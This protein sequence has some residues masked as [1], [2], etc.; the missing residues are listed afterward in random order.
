M[1]TTLKFP[2][3]TP[4]VTVCPTDGSVYTFGRLPV[5]VNDVCDVFP[6]TVDLPDGKSYQAVIKVCKDSANLRFLDR[7][8]D[9]LNQFYALA[10]GDPKFKFF[11]HTLTRPL[12]SILVP[13]EDGFRPA[14]ALK[15]ARGHT[16]QDVR[17]FC[18]GAIPPVQVAWMLT[19]LLT[20]LAA[21]H[22]QGWVHG[23][24]LPQSLMVDWDNDK[25]HRFAKVLGWGT[26][27]KMGE[28]MTDL[29][30]DSYLFYPPEAFRKGKATAATDLF[31]FAQTAN[32]LLGGD[33]Q[34]RRLPESVP[35]PLA[36][37][38]RACLIPNPHRRPH[39]AAR[40]LYKTLRPALVR[41]WGPAK[42]VEFNLPAPTP[43]S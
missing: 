31:M 5:S 26:A 24:V 18:G 37:A 17:M 43:T 27:L 12:G 42:Y 4:D 7:E 2:G 29:F 6:G 3:N 14:A 38:L 11:T 33:I 35:A 16:A 30:P 13:T 41:V 15:M 23:A 19:R 28:E 21:S 40:F 39:D 10:E 20:T 9:V 8:Q 34:N 25:G 22:Q 36:G 1:D 32:F